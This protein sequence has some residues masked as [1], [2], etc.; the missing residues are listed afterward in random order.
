MILSWYEWNITKMYFWKYFWATSTYISPIVWVLYLLLPD[1]TAFQLWLFTTIAFV[2]WLLLETV[3][4]YISDNIWHKNMLLFFSWSM[5][6]SNLFFIIPF[7]YDSFQFLFFT[8]WSI[9]LAIWLSLKSWSNSA[10]LYETLE[11][12][13]REKEFKL[14]S[15]K[16]SSKVSIFDFITMLLIPLVISIS[17]ILPFII[18]IIF[19]IIALIIC[20]NF[21]NPTIFERDLTSKI[22]FKKIKKVIFD[23]KWS[24]VIPISLFWWIIITAIDSSTRFRA[25]YSIDIWLSIELVWI[26]AWTVPLF[27]FIF[28]YFIE[29]IEKYLWLK[30][31]LII[32]FIN[33]SLLFF[34]FAMINNPYLFALLVWIVNGFFHLTYSIINHKI[35][36]ELPN[37]KYK[38]TVLSLRSQISM[39]LMVWWPVLLWFLAKDS[40]KVWFIYF[41][42][43]IF[44]MLII[45]FIWCFRYLKNN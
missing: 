34:V 33:F 17:Y 38:A 8:I 4:W 9:F 14:I 2:F 28:W 41:S 5:I 36:E 12:L 30:G 1:S 39:I 45:P 6:L 21:I 13:W 44:L 3:S 10:F 24:F 11:E 22:N 25:A 29:F 7:L 40:F 35:I 15:A 27:I 16:M 19:Q 37:K 42:I 31:I 23:L 20:Y 32:N 26:V 43:I 18:C